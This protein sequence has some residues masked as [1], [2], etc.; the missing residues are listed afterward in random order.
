MTY[1]PV[2]ISTLNRYE[3]FRNCVESLA[4]CTH[5]DKLVGYAATKRLEDIYKQLLS[6]GSVEFES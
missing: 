3:R 1:Y 4:R 2:Y 5:A 6:K